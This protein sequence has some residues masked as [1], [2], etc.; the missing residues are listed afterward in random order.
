MS[1]GAPRS[2]VVEE[3]R[4]SVLQIFNPYLEI[5]GKLDA[6]LPTAVC[7]KAPRTTLSR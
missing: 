2:E 1:L 7:P 4:R 6:K 3:E 5:Y